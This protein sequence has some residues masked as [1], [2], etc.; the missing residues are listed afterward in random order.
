VKVSDWH[1]HAKAILECWLSGQA[2][3]GAAADLLLGIANPSGRLAETLPIRIE[4]NPSYLNFPGD[5]GHVR[6]GE[7][8]FVGYRG[9]DATNR[10]VSYPFGHGL[11]Y[12]TFDY[13]HLSTTVT[14]SANSRDLAI[15]VTCTVTNTGIRS[16]HEVIQLYV[17]DL[18]AS[19]AR[20]IR[21][22]RAFRKVHL[23]PGSAE[24]ITFSL[25]ERD[26][27]YWSIVDSHWKLEA[28]EFEF[29]VGASSRDLR[30]R[31]ILDIPAAPPKVRLDAMTTLREWLSHPDGSVA[32]REAIG[33][34]PDGRPRGILADRHLMTVIGDFP[35]SSLATFPGTGITNATVADL[36]QRFQPAP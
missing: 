21:E 27:C 36:I 3:G 20:P 9:Y 10:E 29:A 22:L 5:S 2:A 35:I 8:V 16:G 17:G 14:G 34:H 11:S 15:A 31:T 6:Y 1:H 4:D 7:G 30:L 28:G 24:T 12:T 25:T 33:L 23:E 18:K 26:L 13:S 32:L 19:V